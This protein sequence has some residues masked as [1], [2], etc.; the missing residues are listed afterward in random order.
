MNTEI[1][2]AQ[3]AAWEKG[4]NECLLDIYVFLTGSPQVFDL[5]TE[6]LAL[7]ESMVHQVNERG[8]RLRDVTESND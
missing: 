7:I 4:W 2:S 6:H 8:G 1:H 3:R 5:D